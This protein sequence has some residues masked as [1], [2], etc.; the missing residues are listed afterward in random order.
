MS[1]VSVFCS[2]VNMLKALVI[3]LC[4]GAAILSVKGLKGDVDDL[5]MAD[6]LRI[7]KDMLNKYEDIKYDDI[8]YDDIKDMPKTVPLKELEAMMS[9]LDAMAKD[10]HGESGDTI[11]L[12][13]KAAANY[14]RAIETM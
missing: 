9:A 14:L 7:T 10:E 5:N 11:E 8:N 12:G 2:T 4:V 3:V 6:V 1:S 13:R